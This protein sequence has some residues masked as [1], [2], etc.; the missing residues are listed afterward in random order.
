MVYTGDP[1]HP[2]AVLEWQSDWQIAWQATAGIWPDQST[3]MRNLEQLTQAVYQ[4]LSGDRCWPAVAA[5]ADE[6][7]AHE[8]LDREQIEEVTTPWLSGHRGNST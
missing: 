8:T 1:W 3:R 7:E 4:L 5:L 6:L 2:A